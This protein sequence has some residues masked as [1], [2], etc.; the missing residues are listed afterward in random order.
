MFNISDGFIIPKG[1]AVTASIIALHR[2][3]KFWPD[4]LKFD[5]DRFLPEEVSKR[6]P[7]AHM[8]FMIGTRD[9]IGNILDKFLAT[10]I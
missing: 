10:K 4:P 9:C 1:C 7:F 3:E 5:P 2:D 8:P 6:H